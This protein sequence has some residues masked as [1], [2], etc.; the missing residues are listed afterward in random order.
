MKS[1]HFLI[2]IICFM[3][4]CTSNAQNNQDEII[5]NS[6]KSIKGKIIAQKPGE[7]IKIVRYNLTDTMI[8]NM[9]DI[10]ELKKIDQKAEPNI[11]L[12]DPR[13]DLGDMDI[14][15]KKKFNNRKTQMM[16]HV[17]LSSMS[18]NSF[19]KEQFEPA[20]GFSINRRISDVLYLGGGVGIL[21]NDIIFIPVT[22]D[23]KYKLEEMS[24]GR[25][26]YL[27]SSS[28]GYSFSKDPATSL[29]NS[30]NSL[31]Y[32]P[33]D[34]PLFKAGLGVKFN[35]LKNM[36]M[37]LDFGF[38]YQSVKFTPVTYPDSSEFHSRKGAYVQTSIFF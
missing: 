37:M 36:G 24:K 23:V 26:N 28:I 29:K 4:L 3:H 8:I 6:G 14:E 35:F 17:L 21:G 12:I 2:F 22:F 11:E 10:N 38:I 7:Y 33:G 1:Q 32:N 31:R 5:L 27:V 19:S 13:I 16:I 20:L 34:G 30:D 15:P 18:S 25:I 9:D